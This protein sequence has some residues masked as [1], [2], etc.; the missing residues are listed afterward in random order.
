VLERLKGVFTGAEPKALYEYVFI[1]RP[2]LQ[3][4]TEQLGPSTTQDKLP[5]WKVGLTITGP[6]VGGSQSTV[7]RPMSDHEMI[8]KFTEYLNRTK[9]IKEGRPKH[10]HDIGHGPF[11]IQRMEA[12]KAIFPVSKSEEIGGLREL[13]IWVSEPLNEE[14]DGSWYSE[15]TFLYLIESYWKDDNPVRTTM[16]G[17]SALAELSKEISVACNNNTIEHTNIDRIYRNEHPLETLQALGASIQH[18]RTIESLYRL[19]Y[20]TDEQMFVDSNGEHRS[21][22]AFGYPI[23]IASI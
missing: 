5:S 10:H 16:S 17:Y 4:Y 19:R 13:A 11:W 12:Q 21:N 3:S 22:D 23:Y 1:D 2:R 7:Q 15:G 20:L 18:P 14:L 9:Q 6:S 8:V